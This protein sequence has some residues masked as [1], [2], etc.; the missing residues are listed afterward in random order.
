M[1]DG[2]IADSKNQLLLDCSYRKHDFFEV[3]KNF[4]VL[5]VL[6][7]RSWQIGKIKDRVSQILKNLL[8]QEVMD[9]LVQLILQEI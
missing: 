5:F 9:D 2:D 6:A 7:R 3:V 4:L 1:K 8:L